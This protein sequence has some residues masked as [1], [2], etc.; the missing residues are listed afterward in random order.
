MYEK[1]TQSNKSRHLDN[2]LGAYFETD[3]LYEQ[4]YKKHFKKWMLVN[5]P[6]NI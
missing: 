6:K 4:F 3:Q 5:L 2:T 1:Q